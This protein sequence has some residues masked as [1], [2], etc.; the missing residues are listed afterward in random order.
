MDAAQNR[1]DCEYV[2]TVR[3]CNEQRYA[4]I[5]ALFTAVGAERN[6]SKEQHR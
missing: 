4:G 6:A 1:T 2:R 5:D 3:L